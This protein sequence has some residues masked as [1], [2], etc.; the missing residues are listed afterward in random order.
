MESSPDAWFS[1]RQFTDARIALGRTGGSL[2]TSEWLEFNLAHARARDAVH[3]SMDSAALQREFEQR[4]WASLVVQTQA[5][6]RMEMLQKPHLGRR[7]TGESAA[8]LQGLVTPDQPYDLTIVIGDG[9]SALAAQSHAVALLELLIPRIEAF[10][11]RLAPLIIA[12]Q[13]RVALQDEIGECLQSR[14]VLSLLG[15]RPGLGSP[16]SLG[17][18]FVHEPQSGKT[19]ADR[20]CVSNIRPAG[21]PL[22]MAAETLAYL[23]QASHTKRL[24]GV[25]LKDDRPL[26]GFVAASEGRLT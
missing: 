23:L 4:G 12:H 26:L 24:S 7:L 11:W 14:L 15:E 20:N 6:D 9:L 25:Q 16:D 10:H 17:A 13:C 8:Q 22:V 19:D 18:Y 21:L 1:W 3:I 5:R 2:L